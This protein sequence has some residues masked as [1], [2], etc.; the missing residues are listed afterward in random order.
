[1]E[2]TGKIQLTLN[3]NYIPTGLPGGFF[4]Y[5]AEGNYE[6]YY[7]EQNVIELFGCKT[8][9]E[10]RDF[11][12]NSFRGMVHPDDFRKIESD[13]MVQTVNSRRRHDY[14]RYRILTKQ[15]ETRYVED[16]GHL[17]DGKNGQKFFYVYIV[18]VSKKEYYHKGRN[19][20]AES[21]VYALNHQL[22]KLTG[23]LNKA[24]FYETVQKRITEHKPEDA[25]LSF[26]QFNISNFKIYNENYGF[27]KGDELLCR[28]AYT[29]RTEFPGA[30]A[31]R[32]SRDHFYVC[33]DLE[34]VP[35]HIE[36]VH[37]KLLRMLEGVRVEIK[38]GIYELDEHCKEVG[39]ACDYAGVA[40]KMIKHRYDK[41][42][43]MFEPEVYK[44]LQLQQYVLDNI[45]MA[46]KKRYLKVYYQPIIRV[47]TGKICGYEALARWDDPKEGML[48]PAIF[49][50]TLEE[51]HM[52]HKVDAFV[53]KKVCED[54]CLLRDTGEPVVPVS[55][56]L[57]QLDF[58]L[59]DIFNVVEFNRG[60]HE[61]P[62]NLFDIEITESALNDDSKHLQNEVQRFRQA[63]YRVWI[64]DFGSGYSS[65]NHLMDFE[66][67][68]LKLDLEF[69]RTFDRRPDSAKLL[70]HIVEAANELHA[71]SLQEGVE[72]KEHYEFLKTIGCHCAQGYY[73]S[74]PMPLEES[75][76]FTRSKG[77]EWEVRELPAT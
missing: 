47:K 6:I 31:A 35:R 18:D 70:H 41:L 15:G 8:I 51:F 67:D 25:P 28:L 21:Q 50:T 14:V 5:N 62:R 38:A 57:S 12:G 58:E 45:D 3:E 13:I 2:G 43:G 46:I 33:T 27:Q 24:A 53:V 54:L 26:I 68:V 22:D 64:D 77:L 49:I 19:S 11:T 60:L 74:R 69:L 66:F 9:K 44:R 29:I 10:L 76:A 37:N 42:Y 1:M 39:T 75:R 52:I 59:C 17:M 61:L 73:F 20:F 56:N 23:L 34:D 65:L 36:N 16:F 32:F 71:L 30:D 48:S 72:T 63:G 40:C 55:I 7:A 4:I